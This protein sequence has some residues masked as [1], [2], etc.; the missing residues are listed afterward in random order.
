MVYPAITVLIGC[1]VGLILSL[2]LRCFYEIDADKMMTDK[3]F[4]K[5]THGLRVQKIVKKKNKKKHN[6]S[7]NLLHPSGLN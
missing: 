5:S 6:S 2:L 4:F 3:L 1:G 7:D